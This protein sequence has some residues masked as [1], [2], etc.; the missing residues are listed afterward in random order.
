M[1]PQNFTC[2]ETTEIT[3]NVT[4]CGKPFPRLTW[5]IDNKE[6]NGTVD[7]RNADQH[8]YTYSFK[9]KVSSAMCGKMVK[10]EAVGFKDKK[11]KGNSMILMSSCKCFY[12][13]IFQ[14][15]RYLCFNSN[16]QPN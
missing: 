4:L 15:F 5:T 16:I 7:R 13:V 3:G 2:S 14:F 6:I 8:Q 12:Y 1:L 9:T 11:V 10:Y